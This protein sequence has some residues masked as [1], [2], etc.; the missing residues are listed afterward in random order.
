MGDMV[1]I[2]S[3]AAANQWFL[4]VKIQIYR[5]AKKQNQLYFRHICKFLTSNSKILVL[6]INYKESPTREPGKPKE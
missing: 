3:S 2:E 6:L 5:R 4:F 1:G